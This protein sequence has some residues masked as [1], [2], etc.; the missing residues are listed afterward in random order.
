MMDSLD[1]LNHWVAGSPD[2][3]EYGHDRSKLIL[4]WGK[5]VEGCMVK[6]DDMMGGMMGKAVDYRV[7]E[8]DQYRM[9]ALADSSDLWWEHHRPRAAQA[10][11]ILREQHQMEWHL[12]IS[13]CRFRGLVLLLLLHLE[14]M[15]TRHAAWLVGWVDVQKGKKEK[16][17]R[18]GK[19]RRASI[20]SS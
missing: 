12:C 4:K 6:W 18:R 19:K 8:R 5:G 16:E 9:K 17:K 15:N 3:H 2:A 1:H 20:C 7:D 10:P 14:G 13:A 11:R